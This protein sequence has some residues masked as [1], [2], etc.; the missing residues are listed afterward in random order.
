MRSFKLSDG[1]SVDIAINVNTVKRLRSSELKIDL[2]QIDAKYGD[3][4]LPLLSIMMGLDPIL[5]VDVLYLCCKPSLDAVGVTDEQFGELLSG[6][7]VTHAVD[8]FLQEWQ[9][10]FRSLN[11]SEVAEAIQAGQR[12][13]T[14]AVARATLLTMDA[15]LLTCEKIAVCSLNATDSPE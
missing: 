9:S 3:P 6:D 13:L 10:F 2:S 8:A 5:M 4:P 7:S 14:A 11:R 1:R 12:V 15:E